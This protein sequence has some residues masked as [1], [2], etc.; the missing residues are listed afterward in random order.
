M[1][2]SDGPIL[3][4]G[5]SSGIGHVTAKHLAEQGHTVYATSRRVDA[6][7][8]LAEAGCH[9]LALDVTDEESIRAAV[10]AI[11]AEHGAVGALVNNA[12]Y[13]QSGAIEAVPIEDVKRQF[14]TNVFGYVRVA[15]AVLPAMRDAGS[16][17]IVNVSSIA[18]KITMP[19]SGIYSATKFAI[20]AISDALRFE[21]KGFGIDVVIV[22]PG[23]IRTEFTTTANEGFP[24]ASGSPY[25]AW[26]AA[27]AKADA[28][29]DASSVAGDPEDVA[30]TIEKAITAKRPKIRYT[31]TAVA[32]LLP[33]VRGALPDGAWDAFLRTQAPTPVKA[34][35]ADGGN[36]DG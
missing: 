34:A 23:P 4:T 5:C 35:E 7:A 2:V 16:G 19:G 26:H 13:G 31:V 20:E 25:D 14:D 6:M 29:A 22:E 12:G 3:I 11:E 36:S 1:T 18:G 27:V 8:D 15:K 30:K 21:V 32:M 17:R 28:E 9:T 10:A 33:K 24:A